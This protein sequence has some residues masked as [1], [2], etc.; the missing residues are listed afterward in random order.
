MRTLATLFFLTLAALNAEATNYIFS[1][2]NYN[3][4]NLSGYPGPF[5]WQDTQFPSVRYQQVYGASDF[6]AV[7]AQPVRITQL[8]LSTGIGLL[9]VDLAN[10]QISFSTTQ[11]ASDSLSSVFADNIGSDNTLVFSGPLHLH[12]S[13][14]NNYG[15]YIDLQQSFDYDWR[16]G[17]LLL[18]VRD[19]QTLSRPPQS[20]FL[21]SDRSDDTSS[22]SI[23]FDVNAQS[24][25]LSRS[26]LI[27]KFAVTDVPEPSSYLLVTVGVG[28]AFGFASLRRKP[29]V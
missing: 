7:G 2:F 19:F 5:L 24:G 10:V 25:T 15:T 4:T 28:I 3:G 12:N 22:F 9:D 18:D 1:P 26:A 23:A 13:F 14:G 17:N 21:V 6:Q 11:R 27:T 8:I 20:L 16:R 29:P